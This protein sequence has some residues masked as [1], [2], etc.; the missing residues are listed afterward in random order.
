MDKPI[1][2]LSYE[3]ASGGEITPCNKMDKPLVVLGGFP[4]SISP[5]LTMQNSSKVIHSQNQFTH[6]LLTKVFYL[7]DVS[8]LK[9]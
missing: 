3:V 9:N 7:M 4:L 5:L 2:I 8:H 6:T 1:L